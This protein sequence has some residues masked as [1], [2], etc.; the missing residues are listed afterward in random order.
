MAKVFIP[1]ALRLFTEGS[2]E[3]ILDGENIGKIIEELVSQYSDLKTH[4]FTNEG[5]LRS[6]IN[7]YINEE[8]IREKDGL[9]TQVSQT[10]TILLIPS[11]AGGI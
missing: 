8:D 11:I 1:T 5:K 9:N 3:L 10:D 6:F 4:L 7:I 2:S